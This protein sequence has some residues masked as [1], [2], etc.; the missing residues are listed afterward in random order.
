MAVL[1]TN[2]VNRKYT[3]ELVFRDERV[4]EMTTIEA[5]SLESA[6]L[7][8][9]S[10]IVAAKLRGIDGKPAAELTQEEYRWMKMPK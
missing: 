7:K 9:P 4:N 6:K 1:R 3:F 2:V 8:L 10:N 5:E